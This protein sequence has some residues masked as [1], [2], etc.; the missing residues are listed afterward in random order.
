MFW[1]LWNKLV[2][3]F[4]DLTAGRLREDLVKEQW[5]KNRD[6]WQKREMQGQFIR[7]QKELTDMAYGTCGPRSEKLLFKGER[8][9]AASNSC[10]VIAVYNVMRF[11][12]AEYG[13]A[14]IT[15]PDLL[16]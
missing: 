16:R 14:Q 1:A 7:S 11:L 5:E 15:F 8:M 2:L 13:G 3:L 9:T 4:M 12:P 6:A 10:E